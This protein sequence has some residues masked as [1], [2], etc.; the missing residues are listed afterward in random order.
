MNASVPWWLKL[1]CKVALSRLPFGYGFW[2]RMHVFRHGKMDSTAYAIEVS[3]RHVGR[4]L[5]LGGSPGFAGLELGP[6]DSIASAAIA[7]SLG[8]TRMYLV[9]VGAFALRDMRIYERVIEGMRRAGMSVDP[10]IVLDSFDGFLASCNA[11]YLC[12]GIRS[13]AALPSGSVDVVWS[14]AVLEHIRLHDFDELQSQLHRILRPGG[15]A[16]HRVD[17]QDHLGGG[18]NNLRFSR[19]TWEAEWMVRSGF[20]TNRL[21]FGSILERFRDAGFAVEDVHPD[22][23]PQVPLARESLAEEFRQLSDDE[24]RIC[25]F[26]VVLRRVG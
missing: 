17:L 8:A 4:Y 1:G 16:S 2:Q 7:R 10:A 14:Q 21:R 22:R 19:A 9:D 11:A 6:G 12:E 25:G 18:L 26:D 5:E 15:L 24:L 20:Y 23:W 13:L 3:C